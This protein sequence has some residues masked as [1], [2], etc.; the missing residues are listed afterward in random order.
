MQMSD[1][2]GTKL[3]DRDGV[4]VGVISDVRLLQDGPFIDGFGNAL[5]LDALV[6]GRG[7]VA[8]R[9]GFIRGGVRGPWPLRVLASLLEARARLVRWSDVEY[10]DGEFRV[11]ARRDELPRLGAVYRADGP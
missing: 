2:L 3:L 4:V 1:V 9:L 8:V 5:R 7:G 11:L 6:V 10:V